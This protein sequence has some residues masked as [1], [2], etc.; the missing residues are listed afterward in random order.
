[1]IFDFKV[2]NK[3]Y[4]DFRNVNALLALNRALLLNDFDLD[5]IIPH[6]ALVP[7]IPQRL[8]YI[9]WIEDIFKPCSEQLYGLDIG[10]KNKI[11]ISVHTAG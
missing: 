3:G 6:K 8:N 2:R 4:L 1:M 11:K 5:V 10:M 7:V 9:L